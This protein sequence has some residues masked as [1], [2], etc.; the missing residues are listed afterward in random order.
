MM[1]S[2]WHQ[3]RINN[4]AASAERIAAT[5]RDDGGLWL[6]CAAAWV[7]IERLYRAAGNEDQA[8][9]AGKIAHAYLE[10]AA[11]YA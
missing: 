7:E 2:Q 10:T 8:R 5:A 9:A 3:V 4:L 11:D 6:R 1:L